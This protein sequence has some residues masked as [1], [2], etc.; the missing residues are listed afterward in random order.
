V[1]DFIDIYIC[2]HKRENTDLQI[3]EKTLLE[4]DFD[5]VITSVDDEEIRN[6]VLTYQQMRKGS[7][8]EQ[9]VA[10]D[11]IMTTESDSVNDQLEQEE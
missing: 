4:R 5:A 1:K 2:C 10:D 3:D 6:S 8:I 7:Y 9:G 11:L